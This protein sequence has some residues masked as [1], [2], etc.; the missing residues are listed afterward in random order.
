MTLTYKTDE[1]DVLTDADVPAKEH[2]FNLIGS[3]SSTYSVIK[4]F[5]GVDWDKLAKAQSLRSE[6][7]VTF[8]NMQE[9]STNYLLRGEIT[10]FPQI[11]EGILKGV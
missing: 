1:N 4:K 2:K 7:Y 6:S 11:P 10:L 9:D 3:S 8:M 5:L